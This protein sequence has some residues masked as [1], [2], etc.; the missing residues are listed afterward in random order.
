MKYYIHV[1]GQQLGPFSLDQLRAQGITEDT[2]VWHEGMAQWG[3]AKD[4]PELYSI[5]AGYNPTPPFHQ[6]TPQPT[7]YQQP[8]QQ[9]NS[10][11]PNNHLTLAIISTVLTFMCCGVFG[12]VFGII[13]IVS[14]N[15]VEKYWRQ[16]H[17]DEAER[18]ASK[19]KTWGIISIILSVIGFILTILFYALFIAA[20]FNE[21]YDYGYG[22]DY[23]Y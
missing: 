4:I 9:P 13:A 2:P 20:E 1:N 3:R 16:G 15:N 17:Y 21:V 7:P 11:C 14:A 19:A 12:C 18:Q 23:G 22:Y 10:P 5:I 6:P 8:Y